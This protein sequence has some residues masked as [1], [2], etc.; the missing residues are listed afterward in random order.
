MIEADQEAAQHEYRDADRFGPVPLV[1]PGPAPEA[2][3]CENLKR[4]RF[5]HTPS[6]E[7]LEEPDREGGPPT[8]P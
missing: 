5:S 4:D 2:R 3:I 7:T 6:A 8:G 1:D